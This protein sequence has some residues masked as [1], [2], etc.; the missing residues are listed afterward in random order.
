MTVDIRILITIPLSKSNASYEIRLQG[1]LDQ[2][3]V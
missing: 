3:G 2:D 1:H